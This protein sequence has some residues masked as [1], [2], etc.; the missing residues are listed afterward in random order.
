MFPRSCLLRK[1]QASCLL[2]ME[3]TVFIHIDKVKVGSSDGPQTCHSEI[4]DVFT[5]LWRCMNVD[6]SSTAALRESEHANITVNVN[7]P[8]PLRELRFNVSDKINLQQVE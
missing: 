1:Y 7:C 3:P 5:R 8:V 6:V 4:S 2:E